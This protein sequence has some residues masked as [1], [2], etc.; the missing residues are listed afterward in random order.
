MY[1]TAQK[2]GYCSVGGLEELEGVILGVM[3]C[4]LS[5]KVTDLYSFDHKITV[6][7]MFATFT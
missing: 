5:P 2:E 6:T 4:S 1:N 3:I 7:E